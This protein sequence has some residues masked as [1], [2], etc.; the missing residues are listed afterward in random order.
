MRP[1]LTSI[2]LATLLASCAGGAME[3]RSRYDAETD[4]AAYR[5]Y[6]WQV[7]PELA[8]SHPLAAGS[9]LDQMIRAAGDRVL[10]RAGFERV[11]SDPDLEIRFVGLVTDR[12]SIEGERRELAEGIAWEGDPESHSTVSYQEGMLVFEVLD[13]GSG[14][15]VWSGWA[16]DVARDAVELRREAVDSTRKILK[17]FP[18]AR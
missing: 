4:F 10:G 5:T 16:T 14:E 17:R 3:V 15:I 13:A 11:E 1:V 18:P 7:D 8:A 2:V 6:A 9:D 12:L